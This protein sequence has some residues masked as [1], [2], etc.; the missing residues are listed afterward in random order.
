MENMK[1]LEIDNDYKKNNDVKEIVIDQLEVDSIETLMD[2][3]EWMEILKKQHN[4]NCTVS[5]I[6]VI[7][8]LQFECF[9]YLL[10][11]YCGVYIDRTIYSMD[12]LKSLRIERNMTQKELGS[13]V[14][15]DARTISSYET[16]VREL[17]VKI[18]K[19]IGKIFKIDWWILYE[20]QEE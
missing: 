15:V 7:N 20:D 5:S 6:S 13:E 10:T 9:Q 12:K 4:V 18:A 3:L 16:G 1:N 11:V 8:T 19:R 14:G 2:E 17:P